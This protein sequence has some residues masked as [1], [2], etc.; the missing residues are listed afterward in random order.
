M[1]WL[2][3]QKTIIMLLA[4]NGSLTSSLA[5]PALSKPLNTFEDIV[6]E[7]SKI[8]ILLRNDSFTTQF[9]RTSSIK[10]LR[11]IYEKSEMTGKYF[12]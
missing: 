2:P 7:Y 8:N 9:M 10:N 12:N 4:Y 11:L 1:A 3:F 5:K 6:R